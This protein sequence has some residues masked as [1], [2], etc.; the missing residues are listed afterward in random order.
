MSKYGLKVGMEYGR[1]LKKFKNK[2]EAEKY[3]FSYKAMLL[4]KFET[5]CTHKSCFLPD[6][7]V[8]SLK[9]I[10]KWY[11]ELF[12]RNEFDQIGFTRH[13]FE[14]VMSVYFGEVVVKNHADAQWLVEE[15]AFAKKKYQLLLNR[16]GL[17]MAH[18]CRDWYKEPNNKRKNLLYREYNKY[19]VR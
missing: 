8:D 12:E 6:Y 19:F 18:S 15:Y 16:G 3:F 14:D 5:I 4:E 10:E 17:N 1:K 7:T 2:S 11:F 13:V 9:R